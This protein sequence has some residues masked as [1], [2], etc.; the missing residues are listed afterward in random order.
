MSKIEETGL[1]M[2]IKNK[3]V[4]TYYKMK[5]KNIFDEFSYFHIV[6]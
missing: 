6:W 3:I 5:E 4:I 2:P 1:Y